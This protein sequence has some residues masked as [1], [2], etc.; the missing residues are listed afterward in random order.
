MDGLRAGFYDQR[1]Q[2]AKPI[3]MVQEGTHVA[4]IARRHRRKC[5]QHC[6]PCAGDGDSGADIVANCA[7]EAR[8]AAIAVID[9]RHD[10]D[11]IDRDCTSL[12]GGTFFR[13]DGVVTSLRDRRCCT[14]RC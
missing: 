14:R 10:C 11:C 4:S 12:D 6:D 13:G 7:R 5:L 1:E 8:S 9:H 2:Y 3:T